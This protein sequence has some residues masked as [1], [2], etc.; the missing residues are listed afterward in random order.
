MSEMMEQAASEEMETQE[1]ETVQAQ[2][3]HAMEEENPMAAK[4]RQWSAFVEG[5]AADFFTGYKLEKMTI[6]DGSGNK[7]KFSRTKDAGIKVEY[8]SAVLL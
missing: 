6:D 5:P 1:T 2:T 7:A 4:R 8:T 3:V